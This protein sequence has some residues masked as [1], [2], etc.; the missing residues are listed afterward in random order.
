L[1]LLKKQNQALKVLLSV[2]GWTYSSHFVSA[3]PTSPRRLAFA[4]S[5][6]SLIRNFG[7][8]GVDID[9]EYLSDATQATHMVALLKAVRVALDTYGKLLN[10]PYYF[11]LTAA[12]P[13]PYGY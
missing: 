11:T 10:P 5:I 2:G 3:A 13:A 4:L 8:D 12:C 7:L 1:Y 9:W 6:V